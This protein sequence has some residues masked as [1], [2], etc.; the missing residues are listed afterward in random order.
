MRIRTLLFAV[1]AF[2]LSA[3]SALAFGTWDTVRGNGTV[4]LES[5]AVAS[6][7][8]ITNQ[9]SGLV[10]FSQGPTRQVTVEAD[11]NILPY[12]ETEVRNGVLVLRTRPGISINPTRLVFRI[13][14]PDLHIVGI[15]GS[16]DFRMETPLDADRLEIEIEGSGS[17]G[18]EIDVDA[19][20]AGIDGSGG[21]SLRGVARLAEYDINGSG[22]IEAGDLSS[23]DARVIIRGSGDVT[24]E[25]TGTLDVEISGSGDVRYR[26]GA[27]VTVRDS[28]SGTVREY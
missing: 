28:G 14:A 20:A 13:T 3:C 24:L 17:V 18:G 23:V 9:G 15:Q 10:R 6:F 26:G 7:N 22:D 25:A 1:L 27:K 8:G 16:G 5:R 4:R 11:T 21:I 12:L 19:V 2:A